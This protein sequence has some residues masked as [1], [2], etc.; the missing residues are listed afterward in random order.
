MLKRSFDPHYLYWSPVRNADTLS[1]FRL[2]G[3]SMI[4]VDSLDLRAC[5]WCCILQNDVLI[6][7][8]E[9]G[10]HPVVPRQIIGS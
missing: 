6:L 10:E 9:I 2:N 5:L 1:L 3:W 8:L 4:K 7:R